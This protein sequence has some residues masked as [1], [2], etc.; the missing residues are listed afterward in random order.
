[1]EVS[2]LVRAVSCCLS[3]RC[4]AA[5][6][7]LFA[8]TLV[9][10][11]HAQTS[12]YWSTYGPL[13]W[14][15]TQVNWSTTYGGAVS[16]TWSNTGSY[17]AYFLGRYDPV[18]VG[19]AGVAVNNLF[20][21]GG[22]P[23]F[24]GGPI[25]IAYGG[26]LS[27]TSG[28]TVTVNSD[29]T[30]GGGV[31]VSGSTLTLAGANTYAGGTTILSGGTLQIGNGGTS[32]SLAGNITNNAA[33]IFDRSDAVTF[34]GMISGTG[35]LTKLGDGTLTLLSPNSYTG[36]T[37]VSAGTLALGG[38]YA[39]PSS[40]A[41]IVAGGATFNLA[42][43]ITTV[44]SLA[45]SGNVTLGSGMLTVGSNATSTFAGVI[46]GS[47]SLAKAGYGMLTLSGANTYTG[48]TTISAGA[49]ALGANSVLADT[50]AVT[51]ASGATFNL[52]NFSDTVG[53]LAGTGDV[54]LGSGMLTVG[55]NNTSTTFAGVV[56]GSGSFTKIGSGTLTLTGNNTYTGATTISAGTL[57]GSG[58]PDATAVTVEGG[59][60]FNLANSIKSVGSL[61]GSG[62]VTL[63]SGMLTVGS[64][65]MSTTFAGVISGTGSLTKTGTGTLT[66]TGANTYNGGTAVFAGTL[67]IGDGGSSGSLAGNLANHAAAIFNRSNALTYAGIISG[68]GSLTKLGADT[69][70]LTGENT[71]SGN[72]TISAGTL[73]IGNGGT[74]GSLAGNITNHTALTFNRF[75][76]LTYVG[77]I[78]GTGS[79]AKTGYGTLT[80]GGANTYTGA[81]TIFAGTLALGTSSVLADATAVTVGGDATFNLAN[82][83]DTVGSLAGT[84]NVTL[85]SGTLTVGG[86]NTSTVFAGV[87]SGSGS[88]NKAGTGTLT[89]T[90]ANTYTGGTSIS[91]G[92][93]QIGNGGTSGAIDGNITNNATVTF[94][95]SDAVTYA[96]VMSGSG[97]L[98]KAGAGTLT[99]S[100]TNTY[101][102][103]TTVSAGTL[104]LGSADALSAA[105]T[106]HV[107]TGA[108]FDANGFQ[109]TFT[110]LTGTGSFNTGSA[111]IILAPTGTSTFSGELTG[112]GGLTIN[113]A[114]RL[115]LSGANT[116][117]GATTLTAGRLD[118][119]GS[120]AGSAFTLSGGILS[121]SGTIGALA[122]NSGGTL[123][124]GNSPGTL[125]AGH[126]TWAGGGTYLWEINSGTGIAGP[127]IGGAGWDLL[128]ISGSLNITATSG[129]RFNVDL[130]SLTL[131][132]VAGLAANFDSGH[133]HTFLIAATTGGITGFSADSFDLDLTGFQN[134]LAGGSWSIAQS[135]NNLSLVF[136]AASAI[137][138]P[139]TYAVLAGLGALGFA[140]WRRQRRL[141]FAATFS[142]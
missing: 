97:A 86:N 76:A 35:S 120:A 131:G 129:N 115:I 118:V 40:T 83:S 74:S 94:N 62:N 21:Q 2:R 57:A 136:T 12:L 134:D 109:P 77:I 39:L 49:L 61:A 23:S 91:G 19:A 6:V 53:S 11:A 42:N 81:T 102:G 43:S 64:N 28:S 9:P 56:S 106:L 58:L 111:G 100:G 29:L 32:G 96:G 7:A 31:T 73:Q 70:T 123:A 45:G 89:L 113:G 124:P 51:V 13:T 122:V 98:T 1:M 114:G 141:V 128:N 84:G 133:D 138:E 63:G 47:G 130:T 48:A 72:T 30:G 20:I 87:V 71:F 117:T 16:Q 119:T 26:A 14:D 140:L 67:E 5:A 8:I 59:A 121:G 85:G 65:N 132:N 60:T 46:S 22:G 68:T 135:G 127:T 79:L 24:S 3:R 103:A 34:A 18:T 116:Y 36:A 92:T 137:P 101:T 82:F 55:G 25:T 110:G 78:S 54:T 95:R 105:T 93:L 50:T 44:G 38:G 52:A 104:R 15:T 107:A 90:G 10:R 4:L 80:L 112:I 142:L 17:N 88:F 66:L 75:D 41:V 125:N 126:T 139:S 33:V 27:A 37:I 99:L 108:A 69:L